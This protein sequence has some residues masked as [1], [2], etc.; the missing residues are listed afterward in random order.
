MP[1]QT[2]A[3]PCYFATRLPQFSRLSIVHKVSVHTFIF[4]RF[5]CSFPPRGSFGL[6]RLHPYKTHCGDLLNYFEFFFVD[7]GL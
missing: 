6:S 3:P 7:G 5:M 1:T 2:S 4:E